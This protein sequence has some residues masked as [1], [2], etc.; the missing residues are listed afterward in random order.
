MLEAARLITPQG[1][2]IELSPEIYKQVQELL[3]RQPKRSSRARV[4]EV[5]RDTYGKYA[6]GDSLTQALQSERATE[7]SRENAVCNVASRPCEVITRRIQP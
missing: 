7:C 6:G 1:K 5:I 2:T 3:A 4:E